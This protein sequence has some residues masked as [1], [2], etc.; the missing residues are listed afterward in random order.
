LDFKK[1]GPFKIE[2]IIG[3]VAYRLTLPPELKRLHPVFHTALLLPFIDPKSFPGRKGPS[4]PRGPAN[5]RY[6][7]FDAADI[8][9]I[10]GYRQLS[11][12]AHEMIHEY[13]VTWRGGST[14]DNSW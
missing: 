4:A 14:A 1:L 5:S 7:E 2:A 3:P 9:S 11:S 8:E 6:Q 10:I 12:Q 13:L